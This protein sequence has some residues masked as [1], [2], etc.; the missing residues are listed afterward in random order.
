[1]DFV[2]EENFEVILAGKEE[3]KVR[4]SCFVCASLIKAFGLRFIKEKDILK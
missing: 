4:G 3:D 1:M 2:F